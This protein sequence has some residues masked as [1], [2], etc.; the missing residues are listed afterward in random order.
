M[1]IFK[2][3]AKEKINELFV[4][5]KKLMIIFVSV[6]VFSKDTTIPTGLFN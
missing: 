4:A 2:S 1:N 3:S 5:K 6:K